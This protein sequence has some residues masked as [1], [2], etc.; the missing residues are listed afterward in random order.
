MNKQ[1][2]QYTFSEP[3]LLFGRIS[4]KLVLSNQIVGK[5]A[6]RAAVSSSKGIMIS[7]CGLEKEN[8]A[9]LNRSNIG[10]NHV[11]QRANISL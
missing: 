8:Q 2:L 11:H 10:L 7:Y 1:P 9:P 4:Q 5:Q 3:S 6:F